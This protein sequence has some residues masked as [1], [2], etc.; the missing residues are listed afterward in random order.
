MPHNEDF[1]VPIV[2]KEQKDEKPASIFWDLINSISETKVDLSEDPRF[3]KEYTQYYVNQHF[4]TFP[5]TLLYVTELN[6][7]GDIPKKAHYRYL[8]NIIPKRRR[9]YVKIEKFDKADLELV[10]TY[11]NFSLSKAA[12]ALNLLSEQQLKVLKKKLDKGG[13]KNA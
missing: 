3:E 5:D 1:L 10:A 6:R 7:Y 13:V 11:Y 8:L 2:E 9:R 12:I 4:S